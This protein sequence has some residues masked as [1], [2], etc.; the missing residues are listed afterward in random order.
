MPSYTLRTYRDG[1]A[2]KV[3]ELALA[4]FD[5]FRSQYS[6]WPAMRSTIGR[7][8]ALADIGEII[9]AE[10]DRQVIGAVAYIPAG[11]PKAA[12]FDQ[13]WPIIRMLVVD[14][15]SRGSGVGR[16]L[17]EEC[18]NRARRDGSRM[19]ALHTSP[20]MTIAL[21]MYLRMGFRLVREAPPI[22][23]VPY[24]VYLKHLGGG[25]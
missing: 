22:Y 23:G 25:A 4:A 19:I 5:L 10:R 16:A 17:T 13:S 18:M 21:P 12:Y 8:S 14:P 6:D 9:V 3:N 11:R 24:A 1:D 15:T 7:M 20:I 2:A